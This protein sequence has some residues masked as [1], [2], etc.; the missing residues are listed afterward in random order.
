MLYS[1]FARIIERIPTIKDLVRRLKH[2]ALFRWCCGFYV[3]Q[4]VPSEA[5]YYRMMTKLSA[6]PH[7]LQ[8]VQRQLVQRAMQEG[9]LTEDTIAID[10]THIE[11]RERAPYTTSTKK[12]EQDSTKNKR[13]NKPKVE[14]DALLVEKA[15]LLASRPLYE[16]EIFAQMKAPL[17]ILVQEMPTDSQ[18]GCKKNSETKQMYWYG[19]KLHLLVGIHNQYILG[20]MLSSANLN[21]GKAAIPLLKQF[22]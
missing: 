4:R 20:S 12:T 13:G 9:F 3:G 6:H 21:D 19:Y 10:S 5:S 7:V 16:H 15:A 8:D 1:L 14:R 2:D 11:A 18:W 22:Q 17:E